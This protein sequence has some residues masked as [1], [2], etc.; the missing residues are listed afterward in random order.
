MLFCVMLIFRKA[1]ELNGSAYYMDV[2][3]SA[4]VIEIFKKVNKTDKRK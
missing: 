2:S 4:N 3:D 1:K